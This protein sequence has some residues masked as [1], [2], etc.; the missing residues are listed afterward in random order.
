MHEVDKRVFVHRALSSISSKGAS[1]A[2][3]SMNS[4]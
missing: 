2:Q 1:D 4:C 3:S